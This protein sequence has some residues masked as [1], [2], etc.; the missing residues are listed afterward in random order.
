MALSDV[1]RTTFAALVE[2][3]VPAAN[4]PGGTGAAL[5]AAVE[6]RLEG[7]LA[8]EMPVLE[9]WLTGLN[10]EAFS[11]FSA[12]FAELFG[13]TRDELLDRVE[14][15]NYRANWEIEEMGVTPA[16]YFKKVVDWVADA[17]EG[18]G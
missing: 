15:G 14:G 7:D 5:V 17:L 13:S 9:Q 12:E 18:R 1:H 3:L 8:G 16:E 10:R 6:R 4:H 2:T 11:V